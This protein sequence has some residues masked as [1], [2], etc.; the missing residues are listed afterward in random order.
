MEG[1]A[2]DV[3]SAWWSPQ[4]GE[5]ASGGGG[6]VHETA[7]LLL[8]GGGTRDTWGHGDVWGSNWS[9]LCGAG[10]HSSHGASMVELALSKQAHGW[11]CFA[12]CGADS[13][14]PSNTRRASLEA[15]AWKSMPQPGDPPETPMKA[16]FK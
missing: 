5:S 14:D 2:R 13:N 16:A 12:N 15:T 8:R 1:V 6:G 9:T 10:T 11:L 3:T 7:A 4:E